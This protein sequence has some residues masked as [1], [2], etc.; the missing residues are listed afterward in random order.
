MPLTPGPGGLNDAGEIVG[1]YQDTARSIHGF[2]RDAS[3]HILTVDLPG[4]DT[5]ND[6]GINDTVGSLVG[7]YIRNRA[8]YGWSMPS[9]SGRWRCACAARIGPWCPSM[10][11]ERSVPNREILVEADHLEKRFPG[12]AAVR[13]IS[14]RC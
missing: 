10:T 12:Y 11:G 2:V 9:P 14:L 1:Y 6:F 7:A 13:G 5:T 3:G 8:Y 4:A